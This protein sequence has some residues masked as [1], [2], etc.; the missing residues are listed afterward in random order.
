MSPNHSFD[1]HDAV[2]VGVAVDEGCAVG[3]GVIVPDEEGSLHPNQPG[4]KQVVDCVCVG[5]VV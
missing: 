3:A 2:P 5:V 4:V 1:V